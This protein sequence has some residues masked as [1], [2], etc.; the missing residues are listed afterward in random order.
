VVDNVLVWM[1]LMWGSC[2]VRHTVCNEESTGHM[3]PRAT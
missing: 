2:P 3:L 1:C